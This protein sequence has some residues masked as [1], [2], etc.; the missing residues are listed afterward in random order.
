MSK[1]KKYPDKEK[2]S[3]KELTSETKKHI[4]RRIEDEEWNKQLKEDRETNGRE[5]I[6]PIQIHGTTSRER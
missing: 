5:A 3:W 6:D 1:T 2:R 4:L